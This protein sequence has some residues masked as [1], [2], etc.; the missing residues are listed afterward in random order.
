MIFLATLIGFAVAM[1]LMALGVS[2]GRATLRN[3][4]GEECECLD[5]NIRQRKGAIE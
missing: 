2:F 3:R 4:C 1:A 5:G